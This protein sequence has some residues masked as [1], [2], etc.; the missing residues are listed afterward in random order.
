MRKTRTRHVTLPP[1]IL[2]L[3]LIVATLAHLPSPAAA[4][5]TAL[6]S[7][8]GRLGVNFVTIEGEPGYEIFYDGVLVIRPSKLGF[9]LKGGSAPL[10]DPCTVGK[11]RRKKI[12]ER[13]RPVWGQKSEIR[14]HCNEMVV[15]IRLPLR[16]KLY[17]RAYD[18]GAAFRYEI[19][20]QKGF[21]EFEVTGELTEYRFAGDHTA[22]WIPGDW[23]S[24]ERLYAATP[25]SQMRTCNTPVTFE[26]DGGLFISL[27]EANLTDYAG[28]TLTPGGSHNEPTSLGLDLVPWPDGVKVRGKA[29]LISPWRTIQIS[30]HAGGLIESD[31]ILNLNEPCRI[32]D[33]SW[34]RPM[35][36]VGIWWS[37]HIK[38]E[39]WHEGPKH[40]AT[41]ENAKYYIDFASRH[42]I[43][44][45]LIEGWNT[46]WDQWG[47]QGAYDHQTPYDDFDIEE[48]TRYAAE[49]G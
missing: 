36:Y 28:M 40:G 8:D 7:P 29:P 37:L 47:A 4:D 16:M 41:T 39:T 48:I 38:K 5:E 42:N 6:T 27:H 9:V 24:Y 30:D 3:L 22:W 12:D 31:L 43:P 21:E 17:F 14:D 19:P 10:F 23:D 25:I 32:K 35:K 49:R 44:G 1:R 34:I 18:D 13:W 11:V 26:T 33:T 20:K 15:E 2:T 45:L 46:G